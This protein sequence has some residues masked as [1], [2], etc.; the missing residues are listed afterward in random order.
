MYIYHF[1]VYHIAKLYLSYAIFVTYALVIYVPLDFMEPPLFKRLKIDKMKQPKKAFLFQAVFRSSLVLITG[2]N[3]FTYCGVLLPVVYVIAG[4]AAAIPEL[5]LFISLI[6]AFASCVLAIIVPPVLQIMLF[7]KVAEPRWQKILWISKSSFIIG[8][9][10][11]GF[12]TG[13][14]TSVQSIIDYFRA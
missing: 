13:T 5:H 10:V 8:V 7:Y 4:L 9:G 11:V 3:N 14:Y 6:G 2:R 1:R 12:I